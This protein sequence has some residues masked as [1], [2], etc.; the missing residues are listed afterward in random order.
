MTIQQ[1]DRFAPNSHFSKPV[2]SEW[3]VFVLQ[4]LAN[5][6]R[7]YRTLQTSSTSSPWWVVS[8]AAGWLKCWFSASAMKD[9]TFPT[10]SANQGL[11]LC[12][13]RQLRCH[14]AKEIVWRHNML[15]KSQKNIEESHRSTTD[16][17]GLQSFK[18]WMSCRLESHW[19][20]DFQEFQERLKNAQ[21][22]H[23][24]MRDQLENDQLEPEVWKLEFVWGRQEVIGVQLCTT[25]S[26]TSCHNFAGD[27]HKTGYL[28]THLKYFV[29]LFCFKFPP[30]WY[31]QHFL[32]PL[33]LCSEVAVERLEV[34]RKPINQSM[35]M[36]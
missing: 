17:G 2:C 25:D 22:L 14:V 5:Q 8:Q 10:R 4:F 23:K 27:N 13:A 32:A 34:G 6:K 24:Q 36:H 7:I 28:D 11:H 15:F 35:T 29:V 21:A 26:T 31:A 3:D 16:V 12:L 1:P 19:Y 18:E 30:F 9:A 20:S 33:L